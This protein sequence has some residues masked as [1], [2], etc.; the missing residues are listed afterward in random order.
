MSAIP[1]ITE[2]EEWIVKTTLKERYGHDVGLQYA[3]AEIRLPSALRPAVMQELDRADLD[4]HE[5]GH[6]DQEC[7]DR[8]RA[9]RIPERIARHQGRADGEKGEHETEQGGRGPRGHSET[10]E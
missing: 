2:T 9:H 4:G 1:D 7:A 3:D 8:N 6:G 10:A 5:N